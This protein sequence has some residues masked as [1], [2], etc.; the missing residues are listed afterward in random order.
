MNKT[1]LIA[2]HEFSKT[3]KRAAFIILTLA[4]PIL[5]F[6]SVLIYDAVQG[7]G[8]GAPVEL[9][10][11]YVDGS[12]LFAN[13]TSPPGTDFILYP[14]EADAKDAL[15]EKE[16]SEYF[17]IPE[18]YIEMGIIVRY[19]MERE[20]EAPTGTIEQIKNFL[21]GNLL[22]GEDIDPE[23]ASRAQKPLTL[24]S[25]RLDEA[26]NIVTG[27]NPFTIFGLPVIFGVLLCVSI[28]TMSGYLLQ[29]VGEEKESR[30]IEVLLSSVSARQL[31]TGK[32]LGLGAAGLVQISVWVLSV[33]GI[34]NY[35]SA[36]FA[37]AISISTGMLILAIVYFVLGYLL[38]A[39]IFAGVGA[40]FP[41]A[42]E[43]SSW[44]AIFIMPAALPL[45]LSGFIIQHPEHVIVRIFTIFP[46]TSPIMVMMRLG[47][48][49]ISAWELAL[50]IGVLAISIVIAMWLAAKV[51]RMG[52]LMY[53][54]RPSFK[55]IARAIREA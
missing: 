48:S 51:F 4:L 43:G 32:V 25:L 11:G 27:E 6:T 29:G 54:K 1:L 17:V 15:L 16:V 40:I 24:Q 35:A 26:G 14:T 45:W 46:L 47:L 18:H 21:V 30:V 12:G 9:T 53:G 42:R 10:I 19:T 3:V 44:S 8:A 55:E 13:A 7:R 52:L 33:W 36:T 38:F 31:L 41:T 37:A 2:R 5:G 20:L 22:A 50:S 39:A 23:I 28:L 49:E 34:I